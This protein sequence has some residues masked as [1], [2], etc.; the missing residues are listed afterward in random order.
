MYL[1]INSKFKPFT[2][3][4][5]AT[6]LREY[7]EAYREMEDQY[8]DLTAQTEAWKNVA[9]QENSPRA[10]AIYKKYADELREAASDFSKGMTQKNRSQLVGLK[11][12]KESEIGAIER[13][14]KAMEEANK[15]RDA[16]RAQDN[17]V[18]FSR[19]RYTSLDDF[20]DGQMD[21]KSYVSGKQLEATAASRAQAA[22]YNKFNELKSTGVSSNTA[23]RNIISGESGTN[24]RNSVIEDTMATMD[25]SSFDEESRQRIR[26]YIALGVDSGIGSFASHEYITAAQRAQMAQNERHHKAQ[27]GAQWARFAAEMAA[28]GLTT[29]GKLDPNSEVNIALGYEFARDEKGNYKKDAEGNPIVTRRPSENGLVTVTIPG[30]N[31]N[32]PITGV[33]K[34]GVFLLNDTNNPEVRKVQAALQSSNLFDNLALKDYGNFIVT[35]TKNDDKYYYKISSPGKAK[36]NRDVE[37]ENPGDVSLPLS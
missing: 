29:T 9:T 22:S 8:T 4:D 33:T 13:A 15:Y 30:L 23:A 11:S 14:S 28:K 1:T 36:V 26:D 17:T 32:L 27:L 19:E 3:E 37:I 2:Y 25:L 7:G 5:F 10:Y 35:I 16:M 34:E 31:H 21:D 12:R 24:F 6:P 20:L 18:V